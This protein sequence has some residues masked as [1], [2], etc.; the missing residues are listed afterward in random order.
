[1]PVQWSISHPKRLVI[2]VAKGV[3]TADEIEEYIHGVTREGGMAYGKLFE[4][5]DAAN[6]L[7]AENIVALAN[8]VREYATKGKVGPVAIVA[9]ND[10]GYRQARLFADAAK[11]QRPLGVFREWHEGRRW[12]DFMMSQP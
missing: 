8:I 2:A 11:V 6:T 9:P 7:T 1:M 3:V 4:I 10:R 12:I 5:A